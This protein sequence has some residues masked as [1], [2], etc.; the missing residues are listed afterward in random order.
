MLRSAVKKYFQMDASQWAGAFAYYAF[1]SLFPVVILVV[2]IVSA[3]ID[4]DHATRDVIAYVERYVPL[5]GEMKGHVVDAMTGVVENRHKAGAIALCLLVWAALQCF[6]TL[7]CATERAWGDEAHAWWHLS[8][9]SLALLGITAA[10]AIVGLAAPALLK[11]AGAWLFPVNNSSWIYNSAN[12]VISEL[13]VFLSLTLFYRFAPR[14]PTRFPEVWP[15]AL[16]AT[17]LLGA[18][19]SLF[20]IYLRDFATLNAVY[21]AFGGIMALLLWIYLSGCIFIFG[22]CLCSSHAEALRQPRE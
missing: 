4:R 14:R 20:V 19:E 2:T 22:A 12:L 3:F 13:L 8:L 9:K 10:A 6:I 15:A 21:G 18:A 5:T 7:I 1:Y 17:F 16:F 11:M